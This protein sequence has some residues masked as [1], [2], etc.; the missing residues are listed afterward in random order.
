[1]TNARFA[2][3]NKDALVD[4]M[5][6]TLRAARWL[7]NLDNRPK[8]AEVISAANYIN[9]PASNIEGRLQGKYVIGAGL[10]DRSYSGD[11]MMFFREGLC[12]RAPAGSRHLVPQ[13]VP[14]LR[15]AEGDAAVHADR[16]RASPPGLYLSAA[17][18]A[19][20]EVPDDDMAPFEVKLDGVTFDPRRP[21]AEARRP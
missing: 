4:V 3:A 12:E 15:S 1:V 19:G 14:A 13:P 16:R 7:D 18:K 5:V 11:Q 2:S 17:D 20:V 8:A 21:D 10:P 6:A 9:T